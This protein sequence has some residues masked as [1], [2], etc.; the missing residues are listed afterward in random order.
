MGISGVFYVVWLYLEKL[1]FLYEYGGG[2]WA[3]LYNRPRM[4]IGYAICPLLPLYSHAHTTRGILLYFDLLKEFIIGGF[5][6]I[7]DTTKLCA[8]NM[9]NTTLN[10][11]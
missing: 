1:T 2:E 8:S 4:V 3:P 11:N 9:L 6:T 10:L 7:T 5:Q